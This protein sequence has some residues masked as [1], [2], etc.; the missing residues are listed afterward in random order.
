MYFC[1][2]H[3]IWSYLLVQAT[4]TLG[5]VVVTGGDGIVQHIIESL[6]PLYR[7]SRVGAK[8]RILFIICRIGNFSYVH[9]KHGVAQEV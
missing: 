3:L 8:S 7:H 9:N 5:T 6:L 1:T 4:W 2:I